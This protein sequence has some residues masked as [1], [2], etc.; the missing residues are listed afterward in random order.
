MSRAQL[1]PSPKA[2][3]LDSS[4]VRAHFLFAR[5]YAQKGDCNQAVAEFQKAKALDAK[6]EMLGGLGQGY[7]SCGR[8]NEARRVLNELLELSKQHYFSPHWIASIY[9]GLG[10]RDAAFEW[11]DQAAER[12]FGPLIYLKVNPIWDNLRSDPRFQG[13]LLRVGLTPRGPNK[14]K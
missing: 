2:L 3:D 8:K 6:V 10:E 13:L 4:F 14:L 9:A 1:I 12:R 5:A 7:A 11:L